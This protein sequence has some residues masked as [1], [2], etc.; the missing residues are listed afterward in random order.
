MFS[1][2]D[3]QQILEEAMAAGGASLLRGGAPLWDSGNAFFVPLE[4]G[5]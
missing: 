5:R 3:K 1:E 4:A 2:S